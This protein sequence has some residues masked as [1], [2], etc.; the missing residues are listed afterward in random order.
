[1]Q[2]KVPIYKTVLSKKNNNRA[3]CLLNPPS[4]PTEAPSA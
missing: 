1:M 4:G 3:V 2:M